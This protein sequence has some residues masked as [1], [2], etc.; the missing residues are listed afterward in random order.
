M[1]EA[2]SIRGKREKGKGKRLDIAAA[3]RRLNELRESWLN[4]PQWVDHVLEVVPSY[5]DR[6]I[7]KPEYV[8]ELKKWT[9][10]KSL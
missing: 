9:L 10:T 7:P 1:N 6:W 5:P 2:K 8:T 4:P 3:A